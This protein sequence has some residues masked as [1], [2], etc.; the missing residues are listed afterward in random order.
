MARKAKAE[1]RI[2]V[3]AKGATTGLRLF[4]FANPADVWTSAVFT[5]GFHVQLWVF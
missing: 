1:H 3:S 4:Y 2:I 5:R